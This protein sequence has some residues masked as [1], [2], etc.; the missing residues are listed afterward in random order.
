M[1]S[2]ASASAV[3]APPM[4]FFINSMPDAGLMSRPPVSKVTPLPISATFGASSR[5]QEKSTIR[6]SSAAA[7]PTAWMSGKLAARRSSPRTILTLASNC[8][9]SLTVSCSSAC[10]PSALAGALTRS[11]PKATAAAIRSTR[12][13]ID[14]VGR[15]EP[16]L[17][18]R[19]GL[20]PVIA[21]VRE[22]EA[23][24][25]EIGVMRR[26]GEAVDA[27]RQRRRQLAGGKRIAR[28]RALPIDPE[29]HAGERP[30]VAGK[31][32]GS[33][34]LRL[35]PAA[36]GERGRSGADR[37]FDLVPIVAVDQP[38]RRRFRRRGSKSVQGVKSPPDG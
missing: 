17:G 32:L 38:D 35:E 28:R 26:V 14:A 2:R 12:L 11:R 9:A 24:R 8:S 15:D 29:Q 16:G 36:L 5:P 20:E 23:E 7:R 27:L 34:R 22:Q 30:A 33:S 31:K 4:S 37:R 3:A 13:P 25:G 1:T 21:I 10:G 18:R 19:I 6:G